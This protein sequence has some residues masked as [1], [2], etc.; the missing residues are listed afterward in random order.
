MLILRILVGIVTVV[1]VSGVL[2]DMFQTVVLPRRVSNRVRITRV[3]FRSTWKAWTG[4]ARRVPAGQTR[5]Y[6]LAVYGPLALLLLLVV[7]A[8]LLIVSFG[9]LYW[10]LGSP[11]TTARGPSAIGTDIYFS[12]TT[13]LTLGIGDVLPSEGLTR[14]MTVLEVGLG[15]ALLA[16]T[17]GY[18]PVLYQ[19]FSRREVLI[20]QLDA[21]AGS[22]PTAGALLRR[23]PPGM[24]PQGLTAL[25]A[26]WEQ[27]AA[28]L[29][30]SHLSYAVLA[31]YRSQHDDQSWVTG[32]TTILDACALV[33][34]A[35]P[36]I[37]EALAEQAYYTFAMARHVAVDLS[38][39][40]HAQPVFTD[41]DACRPSL[42]PEDRK[43]LDDILNEVGLVSLEENPEAEQELADLRE[44]YEPYVAALGAALLMSLP[45]WVPKPGALDDWQTTSDRVVATVAKRRRVEVFPLPPSMESRDGQ[46]G[47]GPRESGH[48]AGRRRL[49]QR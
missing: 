11:L 49:H 26:R 36:R 5:E 32:V 45:P 19:S 8:S 9:L 17:I 14:F 41:M 35:G 22:P 37:D 40:F 23:H 2:V 6:L 44:L 28:D 46:D 20:S 43:R 34:V 21:H 31:Y 13:F 1:F 38:Q 3:Y 7:W 30:E 4:I 27:G 29:L 12:G 47:A 24:H 33:L 25:L 39:V 42:P 18:L 48:P 15:F 16:V 10:A